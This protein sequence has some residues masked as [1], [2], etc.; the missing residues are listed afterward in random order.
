MPLSNY[1]NL[2]SDE[3]AAEF[4]AKM[5]ARR[6]AADKEAADREREAK[7]AK[8]K[9]VEDDLKA[10]YLASGGSDFEWA[11]NRRRILNDYFAEQAIHPSPE[12]E[13]P[14]VRLPM[15]RNQYRN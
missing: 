14:K 13:R 11:M 15:S 3:D 12:P 10:K 9:E 5:K 6:E 8:R 2:I 7:A 1:K 4:Q